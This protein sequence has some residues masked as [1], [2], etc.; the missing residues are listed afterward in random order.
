MSRIGKKLITIPDGVKIEQNA[1]TVK[2]SGKIGTTEFTFSSAV[3]FEINDG[4]C[5]VVLVDEAERAY[6]G[7]A[8]AILANMVTGVSEG[9]TKTLLIK[10]TGYRGE[11]KG[12]TV[13]LNVGYSHVVEKS[14]PEGITVEVPEQNKLVIKGIDKAIVGEFAAVIRKVRPPSAYKS[15]SG[16]VKGIQYEG[17]RLRVKEGKKAV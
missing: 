5:T 7:L 6:W 2:V 15:K 8:R 4:Q 11:I 14:I 9:F 13:V 17:E 1:N 12:K 16:I 3:K 10:G